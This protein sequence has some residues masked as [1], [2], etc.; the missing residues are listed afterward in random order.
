MY[1]FEVKK[2]MSV[3]REQPYEEWRL[4]TWFLSL[5]KICGFQRE[6]KHQAYGHDF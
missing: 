4:Y 1:G 3:L 6:M 2:I 5:D